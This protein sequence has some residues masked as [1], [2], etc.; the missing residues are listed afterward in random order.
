VGT[1]KLNIVKGSTPPRSTIFKYITMKKYIVTNNLSVL[2]DT[3]EAA[4]A[5]F[6]AEVAKLES[7]FARSA[8]KFVYTVAPYIVK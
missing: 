7:A 8:F 4:E 2:Y 5:A 1:N 6:E 3:R